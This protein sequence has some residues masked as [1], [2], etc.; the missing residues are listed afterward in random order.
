MLFGFSSM[1]THRQ[2]QP[3]ALAV[4]REERGF[5]SGLVRRAEPD[6]NLG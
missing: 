4:A 5:E 6:P 2:L 1:N 3:A